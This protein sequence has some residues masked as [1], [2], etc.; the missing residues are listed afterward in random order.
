ML[1]KLSNWN[2][3]RSHKFLN[4]GHVFQFSSRINYFWILSHQRLNNYFVIYGACD[5]KIGKLL[6]NRPW[7]FDYRFCINFILSIRK[8]LWLLWKLYCDSFFKIFFQPPIFLKCIINFFLIVVDDK[9]L[10]NQIMKSKLFVV[11]HGHKW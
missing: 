10:E 9:L 5:W 11:F 4:K 2:Y 8:A 7:N 6:E 3:M 1:R